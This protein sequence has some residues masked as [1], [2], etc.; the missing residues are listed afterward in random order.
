MNEYDK[1]TDTQCHLPD[2][3]SREELAQ[4]W[5][6]HSFTDYLSDLEPAKA[7]VAEEVIAPLSEVTQVRFDKATD[8]QLAAYANKRGIR[9]S[10]L[11]R[12]IAL[13]WLQNQERHA[14]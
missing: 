9:K 3:Q 11:L 8:Q 6:T 10:T 5:D 13:D 7:H 14:S 12:M 2:F 4:F 1:P